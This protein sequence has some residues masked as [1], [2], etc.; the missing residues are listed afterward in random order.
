MNDMDREVREMFRRR[1]G[2]MLVPP[3]TPSTVLRRT[4]RRQL[5]TVATA[6][7]VALFV[8]I[9]A[10]AGAAAM[11]SPHADRR[12]P[13]ATVGVGSSTT[14]T[15]TVYG[16][17][18]TYPEDW[19]LLRIGGSY[20]IVGY[21]P[22]RSPDDVQG[23]P[24]LQLSNF[25]PRDHNSW[26]CPLPS[27]QLPEGGVSMFL[28]EVRGERLVAPA[29][30][31]PEWTPTQVVSTGI[32]ACDTEQVMSFMAQGRIYQASILG[33][34]EAAGRMLESIRSMR[35]DPDVSSG[36]PDVPGGPIQ[37]HLAY[38][39]ATGHSA[40]GDWNFL[41]YPDSN[42]G[43][44]LGMERPPIGEISTPMCDLSLE[45]A[46]TSAT[47]TGL[48]LGRSTSWYG[49]VA[50]GVDALDL[51]IDDGRTNHGK[52]FSLPPSFGLDVNAFLV[53]G[54]EG[55][56]GGRLALFRAGALMGLDP[57]TAP[58]RTVPVGPET[59]FVSGGVVF[60]GRTNDHFWDILSW[61]RGDLLQVRM[62]S[63]VGTS[64]DEFV[65]PTA[66]APAISIGW[67]TWPDDATSLFGVAGPG[68][69]KVRLLA[70]FDRELGFDD[71]PLWFPPGFN[72]FLSDLGGDHGDVF[73]IDADGGEVAHLRFSRQ[74]M[75]I[76]PP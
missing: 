15:S 51:W 76:V 61:P 53:E 36:E 2:D 48:D 5:S 12:A 3:G 62:Q 40:R 54:D 57:L 18:I 34:G 4:K 27:G 39:L 35:F 13:G 23:Y 67:K 49:T 17:T 69:T 26:V 55:S 65:V 30:N 41:A 33:S 52:V 71:P 44:C 25:D 64:L 14:R 47:D 29:A 11:R 24:V 37:E 9:A 16:A 74:G 68:V 31:W 21:L 70:D 1:E 58:D 72:F 75:E 63:D 28:Q 60:H 73:A 22:P 20:P 43:G 38:V 66:Q 6:G 42:G 46:A 50:S 59:S 32:H 56:I 45:G 19:S 8:A 10:V 7:G